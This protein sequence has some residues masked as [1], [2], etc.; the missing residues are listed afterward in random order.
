MSVGCLKQKVHSPQSW[1]ALFLASDS[2]FLSRSHDAATCSLRTPRYKRINT[3]GVSSQFLLQPPRRPYSAWLQSFWRGLLSSQRPTFLTW[4]PPPLGGF[5]QPQRAKGCRVTKPRGEV[6][7]QKGRR[8]ANHAHHFVYSCGNK[9]FLMSTNRKYMVFLDK[10]Q[11]GGAIKL[12]KRSQRH[13]TRAPP[14]T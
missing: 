8:A 10:K 13:N 6:L 7:Q 11:D 9:I 14:I 4:P 12:I 5:L 1:R 3:C 2:W